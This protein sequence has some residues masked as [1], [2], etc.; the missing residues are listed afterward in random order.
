MAYT[1]ENHKKRVRYILRVYQEHKHHDVTDTFI[2]KNVFPKF[3]IYLSY[4]QWMNYK[5]IKIN[6][7]QPLQQLALF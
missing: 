3:N 1:N 7:L 5:N 4:R 6:D 2:L